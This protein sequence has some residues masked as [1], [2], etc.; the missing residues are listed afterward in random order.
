[1]AIG[2]DSAHLCSCQCPFGGAILHT[3]RDRLS[4]LLRACSLLVAIH[5]AIF[6][7][8]DLTLRASGWELPE[9]LQ[10]TAFFVLY[11]PAMALAAPLR[12]LLWS[13]GLIEAPGWFTWPKPLGYLLA[14]ALWVIALGVPAFLLRRRTP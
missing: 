6:G 7:L 14:Y 9:L 12:P 13:A 10:Q 3:M 1:M 2:Y 5:G 8:V 11:V 4:A